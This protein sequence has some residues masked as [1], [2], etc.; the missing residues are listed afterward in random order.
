MAY[1]RLASKVSTFLALC[2]FLSKWRICKIK[3]YIVEQKNQQQIERSLLDNV[4]VKL[5]LKH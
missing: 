1:I 3:V 5:W 4:T 2:K